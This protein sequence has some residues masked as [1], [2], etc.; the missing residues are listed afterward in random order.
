VS[1]EHG[2]FVLIPAGIEGAILGKAG[3]EFQFAG[4]VDWVRWVIRA[5]GWVVEIVIFDS[6]KGDLGLVR[7]GSLVGG[8]TEG[9]KD[10]GRAG[11]DESATR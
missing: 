8:G 7:L 1:G 10:T 11:G 5:L 4:T 6:A 3:G 2:V 9:Q